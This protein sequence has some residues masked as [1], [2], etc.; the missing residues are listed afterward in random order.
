MQVRTVEFLY[1]ETLIMKLNW[2]TKWALK[3]ALGIQRG[4][5]VVAVLE[6][7]LIEQIVDMG[8]RTLERRET[9]EAANVCM[10]LP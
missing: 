10:R 6:S 3:Q 9:G 5:A 4:A 8:N 2:L 1:T 7:S